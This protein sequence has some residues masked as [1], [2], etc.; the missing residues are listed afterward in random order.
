MKL[1][2]VLPQG[3]E[4]E[5]AKELASL[6]AQSIDILRR[7]I[8]F[9][10]D[11]ACLYRLYLQARLPFRILREIQ[12]FHCNSP[13]DLY[14]GVQQVFDCERW[15]HP[16]F[17]FRVDVTGRSAGLPHSHYSA[18]QVKNA[19]V[20]L[21]RNIWGQRSQ[22]NLKSPDVSLHLHLNSSEAVLSLDGAGE[23][24]HRRGYRPAMGQ[25]PIKENLAS[26]L[27]KLTN[28][29]GSD[30]L[31]DL[32][33][34]SGT[35]L[36]EAVSLA[37]KIPPGLGR[38]F[39]LDRWSDFDPNLWKL[40][41]KISRTQVL[42]NEKLSSIIGCDNDYSITSQAISN[43]S[44]KGLENVI[45]IRTLHFQDLIL[46]EKPGVI[47]CN[48]PYGKRIGDEISLIEMYKDLGRFLKEKASG[49]QFWM[50][51]GNKNLSKYIG[52]KSCRKIPINNGGIDCRWLKYLVN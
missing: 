27:I 51:S 2:A 19:L 40:E 3:L 38:S 20:D 21:Q 10:G 16:S 23:S 36:I 49:W 45:K 7:A 17:S 9:D 30:P 39:I 25:A 48:P 11:M 1:L 52:M 35:F 50:L 37:M 41:E 22:I 18:L 13:E 4:E 47:V 14:K 33:C 15:L 8:L 44:L 34:G 42:S 43:I 29:N 31:V 32:F 28:W 24:L 5:G 46:P 12:K 26:G 6:G